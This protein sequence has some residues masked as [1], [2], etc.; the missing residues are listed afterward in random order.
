MFA[1]GKDSVRI[2]AALKATASIAAPA[3]PLSQLLRRPF[4]FDIPQDPSAIWPR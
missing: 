3:A 2:E 4:A 1:A